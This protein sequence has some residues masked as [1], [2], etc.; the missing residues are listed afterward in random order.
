MCRPKSG[1][2]R[3]CPCDSGEVRRARQR[4]AYAV[5]KTSRSVTALL[6]PGPAAALLDL[7]PTVADELNLT[8]AEIPVYWDADPH[9]E[10]TH[11]PQARAAAAREA[12]I[13]RRLLDAGGVTVAGEWSAETMRAEAA[14]LRARIDLGDLGYHRRATAEMALTVFGSKISARAHEI[15][16][17]TPAEV[18]SGWS[19]RRERAADDL[20]RLRHI[21][22]DD[23]GNGELRAA[24]ARLA[25]VRSGTDLDTLRDLDRLANAYSEVLTELRPLGG[26]LSTD[27]D[28]DP[29][30]V[31]VLDAA[32]GVYPSEWINTSNAVAAARPLRIKRTQARAHYAQGREQVGKRRVRAGCVW[33]KPTGWEPPADDPAYAGW[34]RVD[35]SEA[36]R[37]A[38]G[39]GETLWREPFWDTKG[40][41]RVVGSEGGVTIMRPRGPG[42]EKHRFV[43]EW[44]GETFEEW[45][46]PKFTFE[47]V[48]G[49]V[50]DELLVGT[51]PTPGG[52]CGTEPGSG[53]AAH[54]FAH[55]CEHVVPRIR[56]AEQAF[57]RRRTTDANDNRH[58]PEPYMPHL[59]H[60]MVRPDG[61]A[62]RYMGKDYG[63]GQEP[64]LIPT[65]TP[66]AEVL[67]CGVE[68][69]FAHRH[70]SLLGIGASAPESG[71]QQADHDSRNFVLGALAAL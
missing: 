10:H 57:L 45:R 64:A 26:T 51:R 8:L 19:Q 7:D 47:Q 36:S 67:S 32:L 14:Q 16:G 30:S 53:T 20:A 37:Y 12:D 23:T 1:G 69:I 44:S 18:H 39:D 31:R 55:R 61:F 40:R 41:G 33:S 9:A 5:H 46:R 58:Q 3:R 48:P 25:A 29:R 66:P 71:G 22:G 54:E 27:P 50:V 4:A 2:G 42:W 6:D 62:D 60:E 56:D 52:C 13:L 11:G 35:E 28:S 59:K 38:A 21:H 15:A 17:V 34:E 49:P 65:G 70:G 24:R 63:H 43:D 68:A